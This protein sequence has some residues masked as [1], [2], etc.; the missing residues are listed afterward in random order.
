MPY[1]NF[2]QLKEAVEFNGAGTPPAFNVDD[3][4]FGHGPAHTFDEGIHDERVKNLKAKVASGATYEEG[5]I[6]VG[7]ETHNIGAKTEAL[8]KAQEYLE[9]AKGR[10]SDPKILRDY[11]DRVKLRQR[12][13][14]DTIDKGGKHVGDM[15]TKSEDLISE[16]Q[17][18]RNKKLGD[19]ELFVSKQETAINAAKGITDTEKSAFVTQ[20]RERAGKDIGHLN[21][22][23]D[24]L[25]KTHR[26]QVDDLTRDIKRA[27]D[28][29]G[30]DVEKFLKKS[31][32]GASTTTGAEKAVAGEMGM[33]EKFTKLPSPAKFAAGVGAVFVAKG[34]YDALG[35]AQTDANGQEVPKNAAIPA[36]EIGGGGAAI[37]L[38]MAQ[39]LGKIASFYR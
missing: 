32:S 9:D 4:A 17:K 16:L 12:E 39:K 35:P 19:Y 34:L 13:L 21:D 33:W 30:V 7:G 18:E 36:L 1:S 22:H 11:E 8:K 14:T 20:L 10:T 23:Y 2:D 24:G 27:G 3:T 25:I 5:T 37:G 31:K 15:V 28:D 6:K 38:A 29:A 26:Y